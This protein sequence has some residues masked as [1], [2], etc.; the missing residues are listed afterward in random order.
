MYWGR[1]S[2]LLICIKHIC[3][4]TLSHCMY[5]YLSYIYVVTA[6]FICI[7]MYQ[8][9]MYSDTFPLHIHVSV[10]HIWRRVPFVLICAKQTLNQVICSQAPINSPSF[11][12]L[13]QKVIKIRRPKNNMSLKLFRIRVINNSSFYVVKT[14]NEDSQKFLWWNSKFTWWLFA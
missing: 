10:I 8:A 12:A 1:V 13:T 5:M 11:K 2:F 14:E 9:R 4:V 3:I 6:R 7:Y